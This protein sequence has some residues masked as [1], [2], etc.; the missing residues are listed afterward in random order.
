MPKRRADSDDSDSPTKP[1]R[2]TLT[3]ILRSPEDRELKL[4]L[5]EE[6]ARGRRKGAYPED[7]DLSALALDLLRRARAQKK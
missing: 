4:W 2:K 7:M 1:V 6:L 3:V 5:Q